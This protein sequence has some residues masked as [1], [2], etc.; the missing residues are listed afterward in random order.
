MHGLEDIVRMN[1][2]RAK[3]MSDARLA[4]KVQEPQ[5]ELVVNVLDAFIKVGLVHS[6]SEGRRLIRGGALRVNDEIIDDEF[7]TIERTKLSVGKNK[8]VITF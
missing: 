4:P 3:E 2:E 7:M 6:K 5:N 1:N 8:H